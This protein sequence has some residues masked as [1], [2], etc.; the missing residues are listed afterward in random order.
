[1]PIE[2]ILLMKHPL[3]IEECPCCNRSMNT[4]LMRGQVQS[5]WRKLFRRKY[6]AIICEYCKEIIGWEKP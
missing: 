3:S 2:F 6:C 4:Y 5:F 1:M